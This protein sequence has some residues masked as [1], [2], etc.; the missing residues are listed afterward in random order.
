MGKNDR[1]NLIW[2]TNRMNN[3]KTD[4]DRW[5][6]CNEHTQNGCANF[7]GLNRNKGRGC[8]LARDQFHVF[9]LNQHVGASPFRKLLR[10]KVIPI[11][12]HTSTLV[13]SNQYRTDVNAPVRFLVAGFPR[14]CLTLEPTGITLSFSCFPRRPFE[15]FLFVPQM[16]AIQTLARTRDRAQLTPPA[17]ICALALRILVAWAARQKHHVSTSGFTPFEEPPNYDDFTAREMVT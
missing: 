2:R 1:A 13:S 5:G 11:S 10:Q 3:S 14:T 7:H 6:L 17:D 12:C 15:H 8:S 4:A 16:H 9:N